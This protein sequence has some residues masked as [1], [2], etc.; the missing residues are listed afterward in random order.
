M[1]C[2]TV[3]VSTLKEFVQPRGLSRL[4]NQFWKKL[5]RLW[6]STPRLWEK[7]LT[8]K[9]LSRK[10]DPAHVERRQMMVLALK[11]VLILR[12]GL[13]VLRTL[14]SSS[15][16]RSLAQ[17]GKRTYIYPTVPEDSPFFRY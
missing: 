4:R 8:A 16:L 12:L 3:T 15:W 6:G 14:S 9:S 11:Q 17:V 7:K 13:M 10:L 1:V 5:L 2:I